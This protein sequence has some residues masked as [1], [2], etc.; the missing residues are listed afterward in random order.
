M[1]RKLLGFQVQLKA[2]FHLVQLAV[3]PVVAAELVVELVVAVVVVPVAVVPEFVVVVAVVAA[4]AVAED[5]GMVVQ[6]CRTS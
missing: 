3:E 5:F 6:G 4:A 1:K 2:G